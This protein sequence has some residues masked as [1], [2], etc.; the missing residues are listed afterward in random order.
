MEIVKVYII[1][2]L[3]INGILELVGEI[4]EFVKVCLVVYEY[5]CEI[6]FVDI[7]LLIMIGKIICCVL[8][9]CVEE[10]LI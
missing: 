9:V 2:K 3:D 10:E 1:L 5:L 6:I 7:L 4:V 8:C